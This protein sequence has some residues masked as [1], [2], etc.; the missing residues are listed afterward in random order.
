[1]GWFIWESWART[2]RFKHAKTHRKRDGQTVTRGDRG[3]PW[4][5]NAYFIV[6]QGRL[7]RISL[8]NGH[9]LT[10]SCKPTRNRSTV[11]CSEQLQENKLLTPGR[12]G[13]GG[14]R[15]F[16]VR[17]SIVPNRGKRWFLQKQSGLACVFP[18]CHMF[19]MLQW[20]LHGEATSAVLCEGPSDIWLQASRL[21]AL[22][23]FWNQS[24]GPVL[25]TWPGS[26][27]SSCSQE[28]TMDMAAKQ[29]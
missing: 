14:H 18:A 4:T 22:W 21:T 28:M 5:K 9:A 29:D 10:L 27:A 11:S 25:L 7:Y 20:C 23:P 17:G 13:W 6:F 12:R 2:W 19:T 24:V 8:T 1:M 16:R 15:K 26:T 3:H